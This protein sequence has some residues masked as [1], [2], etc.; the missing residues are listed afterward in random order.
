MIDLTINQSLLAGDAARRGEIAPGLLRV[1]RQAVGLRFVLFVLA[2]AIFFSGQSAGILPHFEQARALPAEDAV[3][4]EE[5]LASHSKAMRISVLR[6][7][8]IANFDDLDPLRLEAGANLTF[9]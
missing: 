7:P 2:A 6:L 8:R 4:L 5:T 3:A 9:V 1:L